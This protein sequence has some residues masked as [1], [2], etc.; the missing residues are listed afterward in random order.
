MQKIK[1]FFLLAMFF[2]MLLNASACTKLLPDQKEC[3]AL[4]NKNNALIAESVVSAQNAHYFIYIPTTE[5]EAK[6][7]VNPCR[8]LTASTCIAVTEDPTTGKDEIELITCPGKSATLPNGSQCLHF[9]RGSPVVKS[10]NPVV[11]GKQWSQFEGRNIL[12]D[13]IWECSPN[14]CPNFKTNMPCL[15]ASLSTPATTGP[16]LP[17]PL[18]DYEECSNNAD[19]CSCPDISGTK[20]PIANP[21]PAEKSLTSYC[22]ACGYSCSTP[23]SPSLKTCC[24]TGSF[25]GGTDLYQCVFP[26]TADYCG[27]CAKTCP[28]GDTCTFNAEETRNFNKI[29]DLS[30]EPIPKAIISKPATGVIPAQKPTAGPV[31]PISGVS[32]QSATGCGTINSD[33]KANTFKGYYYT[34]VT[35]KGVESGL[36]PIF[37]SFK[38]G[39]REQLFTI[40]SCQNNI[41]VPACE[42]QDIFTFVARNVYAELPGGTFV[43]V[44]TLTLTESG[45]P[46]LVVDTC[47]QTNDRCLTTSSPPCKACTTIQSP[48]TLPWITNTSLQIQEQ[49]RNLG[50]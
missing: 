45:T 48:F 42:T 26:N 43:L 8:Q 11:Y 17:T 10:Q 16:N 36:S 20:K 18:N 1:I 37:D 7:G 33:T 39:N 23:D 28:K 22:G 5:Q 14:F 25:P 50:S 9:P 47:T 31:A 2:L 19:A 30:C 29:S 4:I 44:D 6:N 35:D 3:D 13:A 38:L 32:H 24:K 34:C 12:V 40:K 15:T 27:V 46:Q 21:T 41:T 49:T